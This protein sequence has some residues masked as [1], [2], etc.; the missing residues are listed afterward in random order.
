MGAPI[1]Y[2]KN[3][4]LWVSNAAKDWFCEIV[5]SGALLNGKDISSV[6]EEEPTIAGCYGVSGLG[7]DMEGFFKYFGGK[8]GFVRH[9]EFCKQSADQLCKQNQSID[10]LVNLLG[11]ALHILAGGQ[12][13]EGTDVYNSAP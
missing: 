10:V 3:S 4:D 2:E 9:L 5:V 13:S 12:I 11:W 8:E 7:I 1:S 6:F